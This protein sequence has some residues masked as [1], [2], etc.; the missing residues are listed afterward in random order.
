M[1]EQ[2][3]RAL[4]VTLYGAYAR[5]LGDW[6]SVAALIRLMA[7]L[8]IDE[9]AVRSAVSRLK[10]R[11]ML[12][13]EQRA[14]TAGYSLSADARVMLA[15]GDKRIFRRRPATVE[16]G[17]VLAVFSVPERERTR[18]HTLRARLTWLGFGTV[19][20]GVWIA[21]ASLEDEARRTLARLGLDTYVTLFRSD[22]RGFGR[23]EEQVPRWWDVPG[24]ARLYESFLDTYGRP[25]A[26]P[27]T[28][29]GPAAPPGGDP[30]DKAAFAGY[31]RV[32]TDWRR[33]PYLDPG[34]PAELLP[35]G[36]PGTRAAELFATLTARLRE[37]GLRHVRAAMDR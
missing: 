9:N 33:M 13:A 20:A 8:D 16:D 3:P 5:D 1:T 10:R 21:P 19:A 37:P 35:A 36:W 18:R 15:E 26:A 12:V 24:L 23:L 17:W 7:E 14:G 28:G 32:L 30:D 25:G 31:L 2:R 11:G 29:P 22:H 27:W 34:L 6:V 4:I